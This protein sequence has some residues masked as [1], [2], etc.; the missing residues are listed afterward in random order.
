[1]KTEA[2]A[3]LLY[4]AGSFQSQSSGLP[5]CIRQQST[6]TAS[7][8]RLEAN[9]LDD[10]TLGEI[11]SKLP[12]QHLVQ[13]EQLQPAAIPLGAAD[14]TTSSSQLTCSRSG[15][16]AGMSLPS[17]CCMEMEQVLQVPFAMCGV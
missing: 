15:K 8:V 16:D 9:D 12:L 6:A 5:P 3:A 7:S 14:R 4:A 13:L 17:C 1:V 11:L 10:D 2:I